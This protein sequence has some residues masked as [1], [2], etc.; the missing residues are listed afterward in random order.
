MA[1]T[2]TRQ[3]VLVAIEGIDGAGK[4]TQAG[5]LE[6]A[7]RSGGHRVVSTKEPTNGPWGRKLR[8]SATSGRMSPAEELGLFIRDRKEHVETLIQPSLDAGMIVIVDRYYFSTAAYQGA[9]GMNPLEL[10]RQ[11][12]AFAPKPD[13]LV[14]LDVEPQL[15]IQRIR[16]RGD[17][18]NDFE[19]ETGLREAARIFRELDYPYLMRIPGTMK[20]E[21]ITAGILEVL[22]AGP[23]AGRPVTPST[24]PGRPLSNGDLWM[25]AAKVR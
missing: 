20:P 22:Y 2:E 17:K 23:L 8:E 24:A 3:G 9:R 1:S 11:N 10:L 14:L 6:A 15:G 18:E 16:K 21:D 5:R 4:T 25:E 13:L 12:E 19:Q 7:L